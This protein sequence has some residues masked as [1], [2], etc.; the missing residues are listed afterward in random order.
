LVAYRRIPTEGKEYRGPILGSL[1][2]SNLPENFQLIRVSELLPGIGVQ[3]R[4]LNMNDVWTVKDID[5]V[6]KFTAE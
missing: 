5:E 1:S 6:S 3:Q 2:F 4:V